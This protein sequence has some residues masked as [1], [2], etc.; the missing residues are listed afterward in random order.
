[1]QAEAAA[2]AFREAIRLDSAD[3]LPRLGLGIARIRRG[4]LEE[5]RGEIE[6]AASL[7][8]NNSLM[9]SYL[10]KAYY[11]EKRDVLAGSELAIAKSLDPSDPTPWF[12]DAIRKQTE[13]RPVEALSDLQRS[14]ELNDNRAV[15]R[16]RL[17]LDEDL[18]ARSASLAR[19]Y[20][21]LGFDQLA[22]LEGYRSLAIDP[23][24]FSAHRLLADAYSSVPR[25]EVAQVS[26]LRQAQLLAPMSLQQLQPQLAATNLGV[27]EGAG[28]PTAAINEYNRLF[29]RDGARGY[30]SGVYGDNGTRGADLGVSGIHGPLGVNFA[31]FAYRTEGFRPNNDL[32]H[33][34]NQALLQFNPAPEARFQIDVRSQN[35]DHG[36]LDFRFDL[37]EPRS[38]FNPGFR[39][40]LDLDTTT[41]SGV[42][43]PA[44]GHDLVAS[45]SYQTVSEQQFPAEFIIIPIET[46]GSAVAG[47]LQHR[48]QYGSTQSI[49]GL[50]SFRQDAEVFVP[51]P[52]DQVLDAEFESA[53]GYG[54]FDVGKDV[55]LTVGLSNER[56][57]DQNI[58]RNLWNPKLGVVWRASNA[59]TLRAGAGRTIKQP[60]LGNASLEPTQ[61][62]GF[63]QLYDDLNGSLSRQ[64]GIALNQ[65]FG[66]RLHAGLEFSYRQIDT[67]RSV[68]GDTGDLVVEDRQDERE[69]RAYLYWAPSS[70]FTLGAEYVLEKFERDSPTADFAEAAFT[71]PVCDLTTH[72]LPLSLTAFP[73]GPWYA[74]ARWT[75][76][77]QEVEYGPRRGGGNVPECVAGGPRNQRD[78]DFGVVDLELG[79]RL[80]KRAGSLSLTVLNIL[81]EEF[82]YQ[83]RNF[84]T[85][86]LAGTSLTP[87][88]SPERAAYFRLAFD[89]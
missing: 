15:Y 16:S 74:R 42:L 60:L 66:D 9:R 38:G 85:A 78:D 21:D 12:Y 84:Q 51:G 55:S 31:R 25:H 81:D 35:S 54:Y 87:Q 70:R 59:T 40:S 11:E 2:R 23:G 45:V 64:F 82:S 50:S 10:G 24:N 13:N 30:L 79:Y 72:R 76:V 77:R 61:L 67:P 1:M 83:D 28:P 8:P 33:E 26:E 29:V 47:E 48:G 4:A 7:D 88:F 34:I 18:A 41:L 63:N 3:P 69:H 62:A 46:D 71:G 32:K 5:G 19:I 43:S 17:L 53:Y 89:F 39:R 49:V 6:I 58:E 44:I 68:S 65:R 20:Q 57:Q 27:L 22:L 36:D 52:G 73:G 37:F 80:P 14:I 86:S 56:F 75:G